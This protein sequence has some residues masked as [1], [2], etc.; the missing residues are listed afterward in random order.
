MKEA[1]VE[2]MINLHYFSGKISLLH[3]IASIKHAEYVFNIA[4]MYWYENFPYRGWCRQRWLIPVFTILS[5]QPAAHVAE[6]S[7]VF[8][9]IRYSVNYVVN[10]TMKLMLLYVYT[11]YSKPLFKDRYVNIL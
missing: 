9:L 8:T 3:L 2:P 6:S 5:A 4:D 1:L 10:V 7:C 11:I